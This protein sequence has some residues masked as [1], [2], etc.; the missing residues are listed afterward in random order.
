M[1]LEEART[2]SSTSTDELEQYCNDVI[3]DVEISCQKHKWAC[4]RFLN[5]LEKQET[6]NFPWIFDINRANKYLKWM[7]FFRHTKGPL[8]GKRKIPELI[9]KFI[10]GNIYGWVHNDTELR[11]FRKGYWQIAKKNAKSQDLA[12]LGL[13]GLAADNEPYA[14]IY[15]AATKK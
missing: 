1:I 7:P 2:L 9:E 12:I 8:T 5:D 13:Y 4:Q 14:E 11:R 10:F 15:V 3:E 6:K